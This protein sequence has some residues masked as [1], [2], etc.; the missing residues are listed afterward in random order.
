MSFMSFALLQ[1]YASDRDANYVAFLPLSLTYSFTYPWFVYI[2]FFITSACMPMEVTIILTTFL[3]TFARLMFQE[4]DDKFVVGTEHGR[5]DG[6]FSI[7]Q[8]EPTSSA[9]ITIGQVPS[10][11][12]VSVR[13]AARAAGGKKQGFVGCSCQKQC[14]TKHCSCVRAGML[15]NS[16][17]HSSTQCK[18]K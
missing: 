9:F 6:L 17:C 14:S 4:V 10:T 15:C 18:N 7:N 11:S 13:G 8:L 12:A 5:L 2:S 16:K 3:T 1:F